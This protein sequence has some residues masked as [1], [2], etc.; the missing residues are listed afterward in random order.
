M[1]SLTDAAELSW[2]APT[3]VASPWSRRRSGLRALIVHSWRES[4]DIYARG[5]PF[6]LPWSPFP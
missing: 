5:A 1:K 2:R 6:R 3:A 4:M